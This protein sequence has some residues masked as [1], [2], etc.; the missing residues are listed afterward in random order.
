MPRS[1]EQNTVAHV[2]NWSPAMH[3]CLQTIYCRSHVTIAQLNNGQERQNT[4]A[5]SETKVLPPN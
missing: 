2:P 1:G 5:K 3:I 4:T